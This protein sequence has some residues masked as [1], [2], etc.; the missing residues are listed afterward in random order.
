MAKSTMNIPEIETLSYHSPLCKCPECKRGH[1][2]EQPDYSKCRHCGA[3]RVVRPAGEWQFACK[4]NEEDKIYPP[5]QPKDNQWELE[6]GLPE[7]PKCKTCG[8]PQRKDRKGWPIRYCGKPCPPAPEQPN[9]Q[10]MLV[11]TIQGLT[12]AILNDISKL[13]ESVLKDQ[14]YDDMNIFE[15]GILFR[16]QKEYE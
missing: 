15:T 12:T 3:C 5:A 8:N 9:Q 2:P 13:P 11:K 7:Q 10:I 1:K 6:Y 4:C 16:L 14:A